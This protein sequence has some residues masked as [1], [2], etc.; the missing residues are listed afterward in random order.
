M[1]WSLR[2]TPSRAT[3]ETPFFLVYGSEAVLPTEIAHECPRIA[4]FEEESQDQRRRDDVDTLEETRRLVLMR[5]ANYLQGLCRYHQKKVSPRQ[6]QAGDLVLR[7]A[8]SRE[9]KDKLTPIWEGPFVVTVVQR[10]GSVCL[11]S[12]DGIPER[13][14]WNIDHLRKFYP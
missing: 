1:L 11:E 3:G 13:S 2:T 5:N 14:A 7:R 10:P 9:G 8:Q 12:K 6:L 4:L